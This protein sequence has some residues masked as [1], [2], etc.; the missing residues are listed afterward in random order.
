LLLLG[1]VV[2]AIT[3]Y[4]NKKLAESEA[5]FAARTQQSQK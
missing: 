5:E 2:G 1:G 3:A 4:R